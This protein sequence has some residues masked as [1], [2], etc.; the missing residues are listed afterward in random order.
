MNYRETL[1]TPR[2]FLIL[3]GMALLLLGIVGFLNIFTTSGFY[4]TV[5]EN[6]A[7]VGLGLMGLA[8]VFVP[9]LNTALDAYYRSIVIVAGV[10]AL[11]FAV[12]GFMLPAGNPPTVLNTFGLANLE[13][14]DSVIHLLVAVWAFI[15]AFSL[16]QSA[17]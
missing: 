14:V 2:G 9:G 6:F 8:V 1:F 12:Y 5:G 16:P 10:I 13:F 4:L 15:A 17:R 7:H 3:G 11:F